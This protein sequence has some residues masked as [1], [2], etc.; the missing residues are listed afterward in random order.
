MFHFLI[1][2]ESKNFVTILNPPLEKVRNLANTRKSKKFEVCSIGLKKCY[3]R[4]MASLLPHISSSL[5]L[6]QL[7]N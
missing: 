7:L 2:R 3:L 6:Q 1:G 4:G 5:Y